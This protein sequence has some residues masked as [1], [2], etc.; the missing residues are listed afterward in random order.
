MSRENVDVVQRFF[1][2]VER[3]LETWDTSRSFL[4]AMKAGDIPAEAR[5][6]LGCMTPDVQWNPAFGGGPYWGQLEMARGWDEWLEA[7]GSYR[8]KLLEVTDLEDDRVLAVWGP[9]IEGRTSGIRV[10]TSASAVITLRG[11][12]IARVDEYNDRR[13][14]LEAVGLRE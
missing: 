13:E 8:L 10:D 12:L 2:A 6:A 5:E 4:D 1:G 14:A 7:L 3:L 11:G 9:T